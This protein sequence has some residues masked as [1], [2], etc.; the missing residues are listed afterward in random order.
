[1]KRPLLEIKQAEIRYGAKIA[2]KDFSLSLE[3]GEI[4]GLVGES[5]SGK[6]TII[7]SIMGLLCDSGLVTK[8]SI[9]YKGIDL[10]DYSPEAMRKLRGPEMGII[11]PNYAASLCPVRTV[12]RQM[13]E[14]LNQ[15]KKISKA[16]MIFQADE[17]MD[18][19]NLKEGREILDC[20]PFELSGGMNQRIGIIMAMMLKPELLLA[21]EPTSALDTRLQHQVVKEIMK[22]RELYHTSIIMVTHNIKIATYMAD[23]IAVMYDGN[24]VEYGKTADIIN[25]PQH[26]YTKIL[27][28]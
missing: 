28:G 10:K 17:L 13:F 27:L 18:K 2:V 8:G 23:N 1:M 25:S 11:F 26:A 6:S 19:L 24:L 7:K 4:L 22:M 9:R 5:G 14:Y 3:K 21:D 15:H 12:G 20:Y 16:D